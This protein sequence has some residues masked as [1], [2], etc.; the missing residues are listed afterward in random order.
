MDDCSQASCAVTRAVDSVEGSF[1]L[2]PV[3][4][5]ECLSAHSASS[6]EIK[7][8]SSSSCSQAS[9]KWAF[10]AEQVLASY[11]A[12]PAPNVAEGNWYL[13]RSGAML[14]DGELMQ[15]AW[16]EETTCKG[17][18][19]YGDFTVTVTPA[20]APIQAVKIGYD[21]NKD[22]GTYPPKSIAVACNGGT[23]LTFAG[24]DF[25]DAM[26]HNQVTLN[27]GSV[28][29]AE[30]VDEM[31][32]TLTPKDPNPAGSMATKWDSKCLDYNTH[33]GNVYMYDCH[34]HDNQKWFFTEGG[35][36]KTLHDDKCLDYNYNNGNVYMY[37]CH[38][39]SNQIWNI[40]SDGTL[41]T[42]YDS[43]C[44]DYNTHN[45][46]VY[47]YDCH[48]HDN[49]IWVHTPGQYKIVMDEIAVFSTA[50]FGDDSVGA[51]LMHKEHHVKK[52]HHV[53]KKHH[54]EHPKHVVPKRLSAKTA[55]SKK[56]HKANKN[57]L[58][59]K[60]KPEIKPE[61]KRLVEAKPVKPAHKKRTVHLKSSRK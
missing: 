9:A 38:G 21:V 57:K 46:N 30:D 60:V 54:H 59:K 51:A 25:Q 6:G 19:W 49:Q 53:H 31:T 36:L 10:V 1:S 55:K 44:L 41:G 42:N 58:A 61:A 29:G 16:G 17:V 18:G 15:N 3:G 28:C 2:S 33:N 13:D 26:Y 40:R 8:V 27:V 14:M 39:E 11:E 34:G 52:V 5:T 37:D 23:P 56:G 32:V 47:M 4:S 50:D 20:T 43:K 7:F 45:G 22:W 12:E 35:Q 24:S 48:G